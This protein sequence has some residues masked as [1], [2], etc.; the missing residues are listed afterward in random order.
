VVDAQMF[1]D[2]TGGKTKKLEELRKDI[3]SSLKSFIKVSKKRSNRIV[4]QKIKD[5]IEAIS[6]KE[7]N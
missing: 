5:R 2:Y 4:A 6:V 1:T 7:I 3:L